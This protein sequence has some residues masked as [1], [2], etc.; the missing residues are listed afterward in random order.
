[1]S[2][3]DGE[4]WKRKHILIHNIQEALSLS[5]KASAN[6]LGVCED[7]LQEIYDNLRKQEK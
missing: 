5:D 1:M 3:N 2:C 6:L 7:S 4:T